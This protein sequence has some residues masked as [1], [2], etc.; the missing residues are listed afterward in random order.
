M[1]PPEHTARLFHQW[2]QM[3]RAESQAIQAGAWSKL[4]G[5]QADKASLRQPLDDAFRLWK[6][7]RPAVSAAAEN[8]FRAKV[9]RLIALEEHNA[10]LLAGRREQARQQRLHLERAAQNLRNIRRSYAPPPPP[11]ACNSYS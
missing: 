10:Q 9:A 11:V 1:N 2:L 5:I 4:R 6:F 8:P 7:G 3:T